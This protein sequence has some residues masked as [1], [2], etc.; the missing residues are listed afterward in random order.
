MLVHSPGCQGIIWALGDPE[1][2]TDGIQK[3]RTI[4][5]FS[6]TG[7]LSYVYF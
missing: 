1:I 2:L 3:T 5:F 6:K 4:F 7:S